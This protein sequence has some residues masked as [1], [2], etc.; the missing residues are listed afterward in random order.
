MGEKL[1]VPL[2]Y[3]V[4]VLSVL[5]GVRTTPG[6]HRHRREMRTQ[7]RQAASR[8]CVWQAKR[9]IITAAPVHRRSL[10]TRLHV[11]CSPSQLQGLTRCREHVTQ[12][13]LS[14]APSQNRPK[15]GFCALGLQLVYEERRTAAGLHGLI[16]T[17]W[18]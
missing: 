8:R 12:T 4:G 7:T 1:H 14:R 13:M 10:K 17:T 11:A 9:E 18:R 2:E 15:L 3:P 5:R 6:S 16:W